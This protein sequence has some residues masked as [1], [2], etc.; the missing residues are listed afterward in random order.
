M[1]Q[2]GVLAVR[3]MKTE[4]KTYLGNEHQCFG[5]QYSIDLYQTKYAYFWTIIV[6]IKVKI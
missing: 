4:C 6:I 5:R 3:E 2:Q 1:Q